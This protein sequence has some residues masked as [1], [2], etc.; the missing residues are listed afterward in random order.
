LGSKVTC[1]E[2][3]PHI[4][5]QGIDMEVSKSFQKIL[6]KQGLQFKMEHKVLSADKSGPQIKVDIESVKNPGSKSTVSFFPI[7]IN[8]L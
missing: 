1:V 3:L 6:T 5:G 4:G 7:T 8:I 2:F